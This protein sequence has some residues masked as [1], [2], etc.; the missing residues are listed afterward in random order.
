MNLPVSSFAMILFCTL[1]ALAEDGWVHFKGGEGP[2]RGKHIVLVAGDEEY[3]S[4]E[5]MPMLAQILSEHHGFECT[6][7]FSMSEDGT[8]IDPNNG[9]SLEG[10]DSLKDADLM[11]IATRFRHPSDEVMKHFD[12]YVQ[13]GRPI[14]GLRTATH[15]FSGLQGE[16]AHYNNNHPGEKWTG[17]FGR[18][19]LGEKW[20]S[21]HGH[22]AK[23]A[24]G[25]VIVA[26]MEGHPVL[27]GV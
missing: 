10:T 2:G 6:V 18:A 11:I 20:I 25:G 17:G 4:E 15:G 23:Q 14:I 24:T 26:G 19:V 1:T 5:T 12:D 9:S 22:H 3:R 7:V 27:K 8:Y 16:Y 13:T 21:H